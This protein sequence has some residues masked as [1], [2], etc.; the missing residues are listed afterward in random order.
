MEQSFTAEELASI[1]FDKNECP[2][3]K[4]KE[5]RTDPFDLNYL[6]FVITNKIYSKHLNRN[7]ENL[8]DACWHGQYTIRSW[9]AEDKKELRREQNKRY[10]N[11]R[12]QQFV[13][14]NPDILAAKNKWQEA[15]QSKRSIIA[16]WDEYIEY[17]Q[18]EYLN[19][20]ISK[21]SKV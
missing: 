8:Q 9:A 12:K 2:K 15:I 19:I 20:K 3:C 18:T 13:E 1:K 6:Q 11:K 17:L 14:S 21:R 5:G 7:I 16:Q 4:P 10:H